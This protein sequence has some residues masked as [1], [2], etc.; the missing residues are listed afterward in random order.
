[1]ACL[2]KFPKRIIAR[3]FLSSSL[4]LKKGILPP[5]VK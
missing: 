2:Q 5:L 3:G 4:R 1:M